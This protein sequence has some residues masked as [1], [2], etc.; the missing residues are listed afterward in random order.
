MLTFCS[1]VTGEPFND[2][3]GRWRVGGG[4]NVPVEVTFKTSRIRAKEIERA[5][6][7]KGLHVQVMINRGDAQLPGAAQVTRK[8]LMDII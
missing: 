6:K 4:I 2:P 5:L 8:T 7:Q 3:G 1:K